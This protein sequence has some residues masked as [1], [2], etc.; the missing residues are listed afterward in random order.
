[1]NELPP[2]NSPDQENLLPT[3]PKTLIFTLSGLILLG[4]FAGS[5]IMAL[6]TEMQGI[7]IR[8]I[9]GEFGKDSTSEMRN[10]IRGTLLLNHT[11]TFLVPALIAGWLFYKGYWPQALA[12]NRKPAAITL[13][14]AILFIAGAFPLAQLFFTFNRWAIGQFPAAK[15]LVEAELQSENLVLGLL[16]MQ[17]PSE[18]VFNLLVMAAI[19]AIGEEMIF[20]G[21]LQQQLGRLSRNSAPAVLFS[22]FI[23]SLTH[24]QVQRFLAIFLLGIVLGLLL[25]WTRNLW[26]PVIAHFLNNAIQVVVAWFNQERLGE[27]NQS[28]GEEIP[29]PVYLA[30]A[31]TVVLAGYL[32]QKGGK[33]TSAG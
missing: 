8:S 4:M 15:Q 7:D 6:A 22:A 3:P 14:K 13:A 29:W 21:F 24:F 1:M 20:R 5:S 16:T 9:F 12:L 32:L 23:F 27:I 26:V 10:F 2:D 11:M 30:A 17:H 19:P 33:Q 25:L 31:L 28:G 18:L